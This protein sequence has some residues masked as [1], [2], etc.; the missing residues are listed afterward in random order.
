MSGAGVELPPTDPPTDDDRR[1]AIN[2]LRGAGARL[3]LEEAERRMNA[4]LRAATKGEL[5]LLV[6]DLPDAAGGTPPDTPRPRIRARDS[7]AFRTHA[8]AYS[9]VNGML[10]G[11]WALTDVHDLFWPFF[12]MAGW[13]I[14]L[15]MNAVAARAAQRHRYQKELWRL[16]RP[17]SAPNTEARIGDHRSRPAKVTVMFTDVVDSTRLTMVIGDQDWTRLRARYRQLLQECYA[18]N[19]GTEVSSSGDGFLARFE[20]PADAVRGAVAFQ[21]RLEEQRHQVGFAPAVRVGINAGDAIE[22]AGDV[23][24][25]TVNLAAR[26]TAAAEPGEILVTE[27]VADALDGSFHLIDQGLREMKGLE[28]KVHVLSVGWQ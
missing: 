28:R 13:G 20:R 18:D 3:G 14:G 15:G 7:V 1:R 11:I 21:R 27:V 5:A 6:W 16:E 26:V 19:R 25:A 4:A 10:V 24:G 23:L 2:L 22:E 8:T 12:P 9:L 17:L